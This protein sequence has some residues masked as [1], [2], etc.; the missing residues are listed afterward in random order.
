MAVSRTV[1][2]LGVTPISLILGRALSLQDNPALGVHDPDAQEGLKASLFLGISA[3][4][5]SDQLLEKSPDLIL[6]SLNL[7]ADFSP[8]TLV[9]QLGAGTSERP[10]TCHLQV[11][12]P[13]RPAEISSA[14]P[15]LEF[16]IEGPDPAVAEAEAWLSSLSPN[17]TVRRCTP[18]K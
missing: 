17:F 6:S 3:W 9:L 11:D 16:Q 13:E 18:P 2:L 15:A 7:G 5:T 14:L 12:Q 4:S 1:A 8:G 10:R